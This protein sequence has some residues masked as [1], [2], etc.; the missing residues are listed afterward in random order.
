MANV[1]DIF[2]PVVYEKNAFLG[3]TTHL[4]VILGLCA[5]IN[6]HMRT[7]IVNML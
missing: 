2:N 5:L 4:S 7:A 6:M 3:Y 1:I